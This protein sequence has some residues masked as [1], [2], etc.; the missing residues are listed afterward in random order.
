MQWQRTEVFYLYSIDLD[1]HRLTEDVLFAKYAYN[2]GKVFLNMEVCRS[3]KLFFSKRESSGL[4]AV[5]ADTNNLFA[6]AFTA[7]N[8]PLSSVCFEGIGKKMNCTPTRR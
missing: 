5:Q 2:I 8:I 7:N 6:I 3:F 1:A 4:D